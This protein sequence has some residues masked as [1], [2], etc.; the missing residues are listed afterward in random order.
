MRSRL[1]NMTSGEGN[2]TLKGWSG[3]QKIL[4]SSVTL[5]TNHLSGTVC[6]DMNLGGSLLCS[7]T[8]FSHCHSSLEPSS[9]SPD[10]SLQ[11]K[12]GTGRF[13]FGG[14][15]TD[16]ITFRRCTFVSTTSFAGCINHNLSPTSLTVSES[17]WK[18]TSSNGG[19]AIRY[20]QTSSQKGPVTISSSLFVE[21]SGEQGGAVLVYFGTICIVTDALFVGNNA[22]MRGGGLSV[23]IVDS[24]DLSNSAFKECSV[25]QSTVEGGGGVFIASATSIKMDSVLFRECRAEK[26]N[27][28]QSS[29]KVS[30]LSPNITDCDSTSERPNVYIPFSLH[31]ALI[32]AVPV[33]S[34]ANL[35]EIENSPS[36]DKTSSTIKMKVSDNVDGKMF[37][38]VDNSNNHERPNSDSPPTIGR[39]LTFDF[40]SS[41]DSATQEVSFGE[42]EE[43]QYQSKYCVI[44]S[45][46][47]NTRLSNPSSIA[48]TTPNPARIVQV[49]CSLG[50]GTDHCWLQLKGRTL[51]IGTYTV[52]LVGIDDFSFSVEF[53]GSTGGANTQNMF[54]S[55]HSETLFGTGSKL[56]FSMKYE[57]E[58][59]TFESSTEP[60]FLD[61]PR[62][63]FTTPAAQPRLTSV[64]PVSF[65][66][67]TLKDIILIPLAGV[68]L[69]VKSYN[70][71]LLSSSESVSLP[72]TFSSSDSGTI[73]VVVYSKDAS[74]IKLKYGTTYAIEELTIGTKQYLLDKSLSIEV[75]DE[76]KRIEEGR[77]TLNGA[78]DEAI[79]RLKGRALTDGS[80]SLKLHSVSEELTSETKLSDDGEVV[81]KVSINLLSSSI[82]A[83]GQT[84]TISSLKCGSDSVIVN[85]DVELAVPNAPIATVTSCDLDA[86]SNTKFTL[87][88]SGSNLPKSGLFVVS[89]DGLSQTIT[90]TMSS[91]GGLSSLVEVSKATKIQFRQTY[92]IISI[93]ERV[94]G[95][96]DEH[97]LINGLTMT[98]PNG[99]SLL[100]VD[101]ATLNENDLNSV[102]LGMSFVD[103]VGGSFVMTVKNSQTSIEYTLSSPMI[104]TLGSVTGALTELVY[105]SGK[106]EYG[107]SYTIVSLESSTLPIWI[108]DTT[109]FTLPPPPTRI[110]ACSS[111]LGGKDKTSAI[112]MI[113]GVNLPVGKEMSVTMKEQSGEDLVGSPMI[114]SWTWEGSDTVSS[115]DV[116]VLVYHADPVSLRYGT[117]Y[118]LT[119][120]VIA[121]TPSVLDPKVIFKVPD[122]PARVEGATP[123]L[124]SLRTSVIVELS[125][126]ELESGSYT[127]TLSSHPSNPVSGTCTSGAIRFEVS[128][129][130]DDLI[131]L[132]F[133]DTVTVSKVFH[134]L[135]EV[136]VNSGVSFIVRNPP[137]VKTA[138]IHPNSIST[139]MTV[140]LTGKDLEMDGFYTVTLSPLFSFNMLFNSSTT[141]SSPE[142]LLGRA[143]SL[144]HNTKYTNDPE[145]MSEEVK[146]EVQDNS[147]APN[148]VQTSAAIL[149]GKSLTQN[150]GDNSDKSTKLDNF[151]GGI[152]SGA[153][154]VEVMDVECGRTKE[155]VM[156]ETLYERLHKNKAGIVEKRLR[157]IELAKGLQ[158]IGKAHE[159]AEIL[160]KLT[161]HWILIGVDGHF[162]LQMKQE[163]TT[164]TEHHSHTQTQTAASIVGEEARS[165]NVNNEN[166]NGVDGPS[167]LS[168]GKEDQEGQ[169]WQAP[170]Q[171]ENVVLTNRGSTQ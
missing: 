169:R 152:V 3:S 51:P 66:D 160:Q 91:T 142:L 154:F 143:E 12:T 20:Y 42:W 80:Y 67:H 162:H 113:G 103:M 45:S 108:K 135:E 146:M 170:E 101:S 137:I 106:L 55:R 114:V 92:T 85:S 97:I 109:G 25:V 148:A 13:Q 98:T 130:E 18:C 136:F 159:N 56:S 168:R 158:R 99:P 164:A 24:F 30:T 1:V 39:L 93:V 124:N 122:E 133:E 110:N 19:S 134:G 112:L 76:P 4:D 156:M 149:K 138:Q 90:V 132:G 161:S 118:C 38:L 151:Q 15:D 102:V 81:F 95:R 71:T 100:S 29:G 50:A 147:F 41:T 54:S 64:G 16:D 33:A 60:F 119:S 40:S 115:G 117:W 141:A 49:V 70:V 165:V 53:D 21:C 11:H 9:T 47:V 28:L 2:G 68:N 63:I 6:I 111:D 126:R 128:L 52:K 17:S 116:S 153:Q 26:G 31:D 163:G 61:P 87:T 69:P 35:V 73:E 34:T 77:V 74:E 79:V 43:L 86:V 84:Y 5:C 94:D 125:G 83:F 171:G 129:V 166:A 107:E 32:F 104:T 65:K 120:L 10:F 23:N 155:V 36:A 48:L 7:N 44:S 27:D 72:V 131:H 157:Q 78:K 167:T 88:L 14:T 57:V 46:I 89:F 82:L 105:K 123:S 58:S 121:D 150:C 127:I 140:D 139:T 22:S 144:Q 62:L 75:P 145:E 59:I 8:S 96:E 37:V